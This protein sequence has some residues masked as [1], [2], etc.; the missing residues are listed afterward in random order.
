[1]EWA[2]PNFQVTGAC[3]TY[4]AMLRRALIETERRELKQIEDL[5]SKNLFLPGYAL[6]RRNERLWAALH[7]AV[8]TVLYLLLPFSCIIPHYGS[9]RYLHGARHNVHKWFSRE[10]QDRL[11]AIDQLR[12]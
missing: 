5:K 8:L 1:M 10:V 11:F 2:E 9:F 3:V 12:A 4:V 6:W 7:V